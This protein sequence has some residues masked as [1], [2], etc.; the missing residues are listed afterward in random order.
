MIAV[1][2]VAVPRLH[3]VAAV[4]SALQ[5]NKSDGHSE[6]RANHQIKKEKIWRILPQV[7]RFLYINTIQKY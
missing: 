3:Y 6:V 4:V 7:L 1:V 5:N 2:F